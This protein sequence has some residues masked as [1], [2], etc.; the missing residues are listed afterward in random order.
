M[1]TSERILIRGGRV[2]DP[3]QQHDR[4]ADVYLADGKVLSV[5]QALADFTPDRTIDAQH[6]VVCPGLIDFC[7][8]LREPGLEHKA[9]ISSETHAAVANGITSVVLP[10]DTLPVID[11]PSVV[12]FI[13]RRSRAAQQ[14]KVYPLG[15]LTKGLQGEQL[16]EIA[17]LKA[18]G[19]VGVSNA[20]QPIKNTL[21]FRRCLEYAATFE[22]GVFINPVDP[23]L[24]TGGHAHDGQVATRLGLNGIPIAA[25]TTELARAL[26]LVA[27]VGVRAHFGHL[28]SAAGS[29]L[30]ER[31]KADGLPISADVSAHHLHLSDIDLDRYDSQCHVLPPLR[32]GYDKQALRQQLAVGVIDV[33]CSD[34]QP[35][36]NSAKQD[37]FSD[38]EPG[39]S[40]LDSLL[41]LGLKL[42]QDGELDLMALIARLSWQPAQIL[43]LPQGR[44]SMGAPADICI[45]NPD[46]YR[47][48]HSDTWQSRG[49]NSPFIGW[50][51]PG[52]VS[53]TL[54]DGRVCYQK[55]A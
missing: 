10:P 52:Q 15:A 37:T 9:D 38:T 12:E 47:Q 13:R 23:W 40:G 36:N 14:A 45:F 3:A 34:H 29:L 41:G 7:A 50:E 20:L 43:N 28:S 17:A 33:L 21:V 55:P 49:K 54:V 42:V 2:I 51:L 19:C 1:T 18:A 11:E 46:S 25:E 39:I 24:A 31:A 35:H 5:G 22:L 4:V 16:A 8:R 26:A 48:T 30:I 53:H 6:Q 44:L 32:T 27:D